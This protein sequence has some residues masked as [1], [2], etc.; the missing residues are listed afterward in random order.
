MQGK[1]DGPGQQMQATGPA[2]IA[3]I[4][5][6]RCAQ[7]LTMHPNLMRAPGFRIQFQ[8]RQARRPAEPPPFSDGAL[9]IRGVDDHSPP[10]RTGVTP[11]W[12]V[13]NAMIATYLAG[14]QRPIDLPG[15][16]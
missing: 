5:A 12:R 15:R 6:D 7:H 13:D 11:E 4:A 16:S 9:A 8:P 2:T 10:E 1:G 14:Y 3:L